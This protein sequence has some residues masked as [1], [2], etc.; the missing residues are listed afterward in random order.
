MWPGSGGGG[1]GL[2]ELPMA[3]GDEGLGRG[4]AGLPN[5]TLPVCRAPLPEASISSECTDW[6]RVARGGARRIQGRTVCPVRQGEAAVTVEAHRTDTLATCG[7]VR[8]NSVSGRHNRPAVARLQ[9]LQRPPLHVV[10]ICS[11]AAPTAASVA[12]VPLPGQRAR[13]RSS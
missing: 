11:T 10:G 4:N 3:G 2:A 6:R 7:E 9:L 1:I 13:P 12:A 5:E 8:R